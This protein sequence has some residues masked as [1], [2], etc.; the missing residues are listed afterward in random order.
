MCKGPGGVKESGAFGT[1]VS[2]CDLSSGRRAQWALES[3]VLGKELCSS[4]TFQGLVE[5]IGRNRRLE[6]R[7][8]DQSSERALS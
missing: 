3:L 4:W 5:A 6:G 7:E 8:R 1:H 2:S